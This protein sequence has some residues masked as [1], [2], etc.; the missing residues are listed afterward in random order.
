MAYADVMA[1]RSE[2]LRKATGLD[3]R[4]FSQ[5]PLAFDYDRMMSTVGYSLPEVRE[6]QSAVGVGN[7]PLLELR[8]LT[9]L[10]RSVSG[11]GMGA[12][13]ILSPLARPA[14]SAV[15]TSLSRL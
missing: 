12:R 6:I 3:Y 13:R 11:P 1:R 2:I 7:T 5:G 8:N 4:E 10:A 15:P 9:E 14:W